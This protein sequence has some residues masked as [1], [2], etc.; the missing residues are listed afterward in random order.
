M[1]RGNCTA[2]TV[3]LQPHKEEGE[4]GKTSQM[5]EQVESLKAAYKTE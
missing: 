4:K 1:N 5:Q 3:L 2:T